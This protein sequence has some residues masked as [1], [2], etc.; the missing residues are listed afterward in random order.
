MMYDLF[1]KCLNASY[2][3]TENDGNFAVEYRDDTMYIMFQETSTK[4]DWKNN[5]DFPA[6][7]YK[8]MDIKWKCHRGFLRVWKSIK[9]YLKQRILDTDIKH[10]YVLG[11]SMG[12]ALA[13]FCHEY[14]WF[15][16]P[17][18]RE[19]GLEGFGFGCPRVYFGRM[20]KALKNRWKHFHIIRNGNDL[21]THVPPAIFGYRHVNKVY[22]LKNK[23]MLH[24]FTKVKSINAHFAQNYSDSLM[25]ETISGEHYD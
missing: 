17:D 19:N 12:A 18:L 7:P 2:V 14:V 9:P 16:R 11:Y 8:D 23:T 1:Q 4:T 5:F 24:T 20:K 15:N 10:I 6:V 22:K 25:E 21:V 13:V 3:L